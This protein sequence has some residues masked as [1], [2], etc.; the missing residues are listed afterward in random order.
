ME[1]RLGYLK[2]ILSIE[3]KNQ[4]KKVVNEN[5]IL[6]IK[7]KR[8]VHVDKNSLSGITHIFVYPNR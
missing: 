1:L 5:P 4:S 8:N 7:S 3:K 6:K 2:I